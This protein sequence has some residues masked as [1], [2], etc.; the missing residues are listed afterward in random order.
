M[1]NRFQPRL[2]RGEHLV[3]GETGELVAEAFEVAESV[4]VNEADEAEQFEQRILQR[5]GGEQEL[6]LARQHCLQRVRDDVGRLVNIP[7]PVR[8]IN[9][10]QIP[11]HRGD[12]RG[13]VAGELVGADYDGI[14]LERL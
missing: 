11:R 5:R 4:L 10:D 2:E 6:V 12:V 14:A 13:L 7:E 3:L 9:H 1:A 8:F